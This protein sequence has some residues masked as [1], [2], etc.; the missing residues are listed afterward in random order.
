MY[1]TQS[2]ACTAP[3]SLQPPSKADILRGI[4]MLASMEAKVR[5][6]RQAYN[7]LFYRGDLNTNGWPL[8][9]YGGTPSSTVTGC[10]SPQSSGQ[11][12]QSGLSSTP[13]VGLNLTGLQ[14]WPSLMVTLPDAIGVP[15]NS[16]A[17]VPQPPA[18][19]FPPLTTQAHTQAAKQ[20]VKQATAATTPVP[21][22]CPPYPTTGN[23]CLDL[24]LNYVDPS[25]VSAT[26]LLLCAQKGYQGNTDGPKLTPQ[27][28]ACRAANY[29]T[30]PKIPDNTNI[31][32]YNAATMGM[33][34]WDSASFLQG[35]LTAVGAGA[36][37][38]F[39]YNEGKRRGYI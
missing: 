14:Y 2:D 31:P 15:P 34:D 32:A 18:P 17:A 8:A 22:T 28:L 33:G 39:L 13:G 26:Q 19:T 10:P 25:Q 1:V 30:L 21:A 38:V 4:R 35:L 16:P 6:A 27:M 23:L 5:A 11:P 3:N 20:L 9:T 7:C 37:V 24:M 29:A 36:A 12:D